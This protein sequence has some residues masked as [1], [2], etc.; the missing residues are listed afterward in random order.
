MTAF[1]PATSGRARPSSVSKNMIVE[2]TLSS[3]PQ[4]LHA[5]GRPNIV[6]TL[7]ESRTISY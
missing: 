2:W 6:I 4:C 1:G 5:D 3:P 7:S